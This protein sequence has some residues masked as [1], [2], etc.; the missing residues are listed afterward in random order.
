MCHPWQP[1]QEPGPESTNRSPTMS[2]QQATS[3]QQEAPTNKPPKHRSTMFNSE[4]FLASL[5][6][7]SAVKQPPILVCNL[8]H[9]RSN[10]V[11]HASTKPAVHWFTKCTMNFCGGYHGWQ[12]R[13]AGKALHTQPANNQVIHFKD[14]Q[15]TWG[16]PLAPRSS[17]QTPGTNFSHWPCGSPVEH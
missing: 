12:P 15:P 3:N 16:T 1:C 14:G 6:I 10:G 2:N 7:R 5:P 8:S 13:F 4:V 11:Q 9:V 17:E